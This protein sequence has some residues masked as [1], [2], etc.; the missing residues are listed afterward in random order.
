MNLKARLLTLL[1]ALAAIAQCGGQK[2]LSA[3]VDFESRNEE[4]IVIRGDLTIGTGDE[5]VT[6]EAPWFLWQY[7]FTNKT[8]KNLNVATV[9]FKIRSRKNGVRSEQE[10]VLDPGT[11]C[12]FR[13]LLAFAAP[14]TTSSGATN[15]DVTDQQD[16]TALEYEDNFIHGLSESDNGIYTVD[17]EAVG[18]FEDATNGDIVERYE[19]YDFLTT[20]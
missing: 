8:D 10:F 14:N 9:I 17:V 18:W 2:G 1:L 4:P 15:C 7:S 3:Q 16:P 5:Q 11:S 12:E 19:G 6:I 20:R 13:P